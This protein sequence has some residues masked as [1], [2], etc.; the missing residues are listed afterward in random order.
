MSDHRSI[1]GNPNCAGCQTR[2]H[3][4]MPEEIPRAVKE[5]RLALFA[6]AGVSTEAR[7]VFPHTFYEE[8]AAEL[9][10]DLSEDLPFPALMSR[11]CRIRGRRELLIRI[12]KRFDY[13]DSF[14]EVCSRASRFHETVSTIPFLQEIF[15]TNWDELFEDVCG[16]TPIV[17]SEDYAFWDLPGRKVFKLHGSVSHYGSIVAT[18]ED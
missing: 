3:F 8:I 11:F 1:C 7:G 14:P 17:S 4:E 5:G 9:G 16:A 6:G 18:E 2:F 10:I 13:L 12:K 15:T